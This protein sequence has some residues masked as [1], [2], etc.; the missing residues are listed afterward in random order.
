VQSQTIEN[1]PQVDLF[2]HHRDSIVSLQDRLM[3]LAGRILWDAK[4]HLQGEQYEE[5]VVGRSSKH[6]LTMAGLIHLKSTLA[7]SDRELVAP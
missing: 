6:T 5:A 4:N 7:L 1:A 2:C 3:R